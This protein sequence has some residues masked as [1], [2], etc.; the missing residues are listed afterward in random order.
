MLGSRYNTFRVLLLVSISLWTLNLTSQTSVLRHYSIKEGLPSSECYNIFQD[1]KKYLWIGTDAGVVR[2]SGYE[3]RTF[4]SSKGLVDNTVFKIHEDR[5]GRIWFATYSGKMCYYSYDTDSIYSIPVNVQLS[6]LVKSF[7]LDFTFDHSD[8]LYISNYLCGYI[9]VFPPFYKELKNYH[10]NTNEIYLNE[11]DKHSFIFGNDFEDIISIPK[12]MGIS[13][14]D[15]FNKPFKS[16]S[17]PLYLNRV[18]THVSAIKKK[19][20][21]YLITDGT[22]ILKANKT[23]FTILLDS[24]KDYQSKGAILNIT[25]DSKNR[26]WVNTKGHGSYIYK[27]AD[28]TSTPEICLPNLTVSYV[29][30]DEDKGIWLST[31]EEGLFY[32]PSFEFS[33]FNKNSGFNLDKVLSIFKYQTKLYALTID[34][35]LNV[36]DLS[37]KKHQY[38][39]A[40]FNYASWYLAGSDSLLLCCGSDPLMINLKTKEKKVLWRTINGVYTIA[41]VKK[42][43]PYT[44]E[45]FLGFNSR[46]VFSIDKNTAE[47]KRIKIDI[48]SPFSLCVDN[49][50]ILVGTKEGLFSLKD[51]ELTYLGDKY[52]VLKNRIIDIVKSGDNLYFATRGA[53]VICMRKG[54]ILQQFNESNGL[55]SN[56]C[57]SMIKDDQGKIWVGTN[58]GI[59]KVEFKND[60]FSINT[61]NLA[62]GFVSNEINQ[63]IKENEL[64]YFATSSGI[65]VVNVEELY[66]EKSNIP[67]YIENFV[68]NGERKRSD[69]SYVFLHEQN[70]IK[71][72]YKAICLKNEGDLKYKYRL[73]G[74][75]TNWTYTKDVFAQYTVLQPGRYKF[76]VYVL[77]PSGLIPFKSKTISFQIEAPFWRT[78]WFLL[79]V[80]SL[81]IFGGVLFY[82][83]RVAAVR[84]QEAEKTLIH[85]KI[86]ESELKALRTQMNPHF[87]FNAIN[88][89]QSFVLKNDAQSAHKYLTK[90]ARL[91]RS[92]LENSKRETILLSQEIESLTLY[93]ELEALR[94][95]FSF[96][97]SINVHTSTNTD[98]V[99]VPPMLIQPYVENAIL[100][101]LMPLTERRGQ[102]NIDFSQ[103]GTILKCKIEDNGI[104]RKAAEEIKRK[105][106]KTHISMGM[107]VTQERLEILNKQNGVPTQVNIVDKIEEG[108]V[109]GTI[110]EICIDLKNN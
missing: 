41:S 30:E 18:L 22:S 49:D 26:V 48:P 11:L 55:P 93:I 20:G 110:V 15:K 63:L 47:C 61:M 75:D 1:S 85:K 33:F 87:I 17:P 83:N 39:E 21:D 36:V 28:F 64:L 105:K 51:K 7:P 42:A 44:S 80:F 91:I 31:I 3:F 57:T 56:I 99:F 96:D 101:G 14:R 107:S 68:V 59:F 102:L 27:D 43:I 72:Y 108:Q 32:I 45:S 86:A 73:E 100:H 19:N 23:G 98:S 78:W 67:L 70:S 109:T 10:F 71:I 60:L 106:T 34:N 38:V 95:S 40:K 24:I 6:D 52:P 29:L 97:F 25:I 46:E 2:F 5:K 89:I 88:S 69:S 35:N 37:K 74:L 79:F 8:T 12:K 16:S 53:G 77:D 9:K 58:R 66:T 54:K 84:K 104:G 94:S 4:N 92:V 82:Y 13:F 90:F 103:E 62:N 50:R 81:I 76:V 65:G